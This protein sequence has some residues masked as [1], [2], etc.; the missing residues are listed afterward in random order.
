MADVLLF[1]HVLGRTEGILHLAEQLQQA[2]H[3]VHTP[4]LF[5]GRT[6]ETID[7]G[8]AYVKETGYDTLTERAGQAADGLPEAVVYAGYSLGVMA[9]QQLAQT[10]SNARGALFIA[11]CAPAEEFG[12]PWPAELPVQVHGTKGDHF[13]ADEEDLEAAQKITEASDSGELFLYPGDQHFFAD[14]SQPGYDA[15][16][17]AQMVERMLSFLKR[18]D[19]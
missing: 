7:E 6:F 19:E 4:D 16:A 13:F 8:F 1:H 18:I 2:G 12:S 10:K 9:A 5:E 15:D 14:N 11:S 17:T 3:A